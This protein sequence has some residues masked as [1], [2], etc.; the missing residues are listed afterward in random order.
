MSDA[1][2]LFAAQLFAVGIHDAQ[3]EH[4]FHKVR[5]W[6][7][8][9]AWQDKKIAVEIEG[10]TFSGG[11]HTRGIGFRNDCEK[12]NT[13]TLDGWRVF[14]FPAEQIKTGA[15]LKVIEEAHE[16]FTA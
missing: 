9:F 4:R 6:R 2:D 1:E 5:R 7:F 8:D 14:R 15:P 13:A 16:K 3:R 11:R 12:Y 10:G